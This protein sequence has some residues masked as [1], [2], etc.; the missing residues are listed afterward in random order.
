MRAWTH[1]I[2]STGCMHQAGWQPLLPE[3]ADWMGMDE[4]MVAFALDLSAPASGDAA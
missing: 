3:I 1:L 4:A 2:W